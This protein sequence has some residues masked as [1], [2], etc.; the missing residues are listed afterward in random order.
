M[1]ST[2]SLVTF[3]QQFIND[4]ETALVLILLGV[5]VIALYR[6]WV[7]PKTYH[8]KTEERAS[9][10]EKSLEEVTEALNDLTVEIRQR[11]PSRRG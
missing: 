9:R 3:F 6:G 5:A 1:D 8:E 4:P 7:V 10:A 2:G 11:A